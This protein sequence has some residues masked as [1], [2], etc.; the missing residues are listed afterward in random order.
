MG[1]STLFE[2]VGNLVPSVD[3][4]LLGYCLSRPGLIGQICD[5]LLW[6]A[7]VTKPAAR[8]L[9]IPRKIASYSSIYEFRTLIDTD[10]HLR[11]G[12]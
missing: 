9:L 8:T 6:P 12:S 1:I 5:G 4:L 7:C 3:M 10:A 2:M 11:S